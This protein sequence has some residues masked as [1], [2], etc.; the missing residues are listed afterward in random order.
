MV[1]AG[2][3]GTASSGTDGPLVGTT[4]VQAYREHDLK[5]GD[6]VLIIG[7]S[8]G[9]GHVAVQIANKFGAVVTG[10]RVRAANHIAPDQEDVHIAA[11]SANAVAT[12]ARGGPRQSALAGARFL[13][14]A[15]SW[16]PGIRGVNSTLKCAAL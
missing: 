10:V 6:K 1:G 4:T 13:R 3:D 2:E 5:E 9:V 8:G 15:P 11:A 12:V 7:A 16:R 14:A